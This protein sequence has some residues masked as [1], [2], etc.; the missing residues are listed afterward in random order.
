M[1][2]F[3]NRPNTVRIDGV[4]SGTVLAAVGRYGDVL[5]AYY[6]TFYSVRVDAKS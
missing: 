2:E 6:G 5:W 1:L 3:T 4:V